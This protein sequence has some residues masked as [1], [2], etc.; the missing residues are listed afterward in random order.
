M[1]VSAGLLD[2]S[3]GL[4]AGYTS[5]LTT[6]GAPTVRFSPSTVQPRIG[7]S[8]GTV[9]PDPIVVAANDSLRI[10]TGTFAPPTLTN[11]GFLA[12]EGNAVLNTA[13]T[14]NLG[15]AI[16]VRG[17]NTTS[18]ASVTI[19]NGFT[20]A[21]IFRLVAEGAG[22]SVAASLGAGTLTNAATGT[23]EFLSGAG[24]TRAIAAGLVDNFGAFNAA[25]SGAVNGPLDQRGSLTVAAT[26]TL[27]VTGL[28][29]L[30]DGSTTTVLGTFTK[31]GG[32]SATVG[33][34][35]SGTTCP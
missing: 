24:G 27:T 18:A 14:S 19:T 29:R 15:S 26:Q 28:T 4:L 11:N 35:F 13:L 30:L 21:G 20:N 22:Y 9:L 7:F 25:Y 2:L 1:S 3:A 31:S 34:S 6:T 23:L 16:V 12:L 33:A 8:A 32:C 17:T 5:Y 10:Y